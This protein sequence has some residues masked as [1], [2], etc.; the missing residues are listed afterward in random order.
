MNDRPVRPALA[1]KLAELVAQA[2]AGDAAFGP[3]AVQAE[4]LAAAAGTRQSE[5]WVTAQ[6]ALSAATAARGPTETA[7]GD[8]D[9]LGA[10]LLQAQGGIAPNDLAAIKNAGAEVG[11]IDQRQVNRIKTIQE[12]LGL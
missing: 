9:A 11:A 7:L 4:R 8:I 3:A 5:S 2:R 6:V 12:R 1:S 10:E